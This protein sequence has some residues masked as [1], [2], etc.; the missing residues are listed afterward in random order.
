MIVHIEQMPLNIVRPRTGAGRL[1]VD[2]RPQIVL[3][4]IH[5]APAPGIAFLPEHRLLGFAVCPTD[6]GVV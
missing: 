3:E 6:H 4:P 1:I 2:H 5:H